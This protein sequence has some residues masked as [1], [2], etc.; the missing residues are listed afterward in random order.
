[1]SCLDAAL[2]YAAR[3]WHVLPL[4]TPEASGCSCGKPECSS[5]G[6]HPRTKDGLASA[7]TDPETIREWWRRWP[8]S[9]VGIRTG[10]IS[11]LAV[12][13]I[14][15]DD[16]KA[17]LLSLQETHGQLPPTQRAWTG[18]A[19]ADGKR[20]GCHYFFAMPGGGLRNSAGLAGK[21]LD[22]RGDGGYVV[23]APSKH[24]SGLSY[25]WIKSDAPVAE[26]PEWLVEV[27]AQHKPALV[28]APKASASPAPQ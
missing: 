8:S 7:T 16:G 10:A 2:R 28:A 24:A 3:G 14:D 23:A 25:Q 19:G 11:G 6:K 12:L 22:V 26:M 27:L 21:G 1:M 5:V 4:H 20:K 13:D 15:G 17:A 9:N 18:R